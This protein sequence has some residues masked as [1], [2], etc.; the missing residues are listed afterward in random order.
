MKSMVAGFSAGIL[1][2]LGLG[3]SGMTMPSKVI[4]FLDFFGAWD[5]SLMFVMVGA[6]A[7]HFPLYRLFIT[8][9][10][11]LFDVRF[12]VPEGKAVDARLLLGA[13]IFGAGWGLGG[14]CP[15]PSLVGIASG[16]LPVLA[17]VASMAAGMKLEHAVSGRS[18]SA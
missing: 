18:T 8:R 16:A 12:H 6:I 4:G 2:A 11:P 10:M 17:F 9:P 5:P 13:A 15:G 7:V 3:V 14:F 1:F